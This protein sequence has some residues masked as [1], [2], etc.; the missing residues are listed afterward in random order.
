MYGFAPVKG[1]GAGVFKQSCGQLCTQNVS[2][3][4]VYQCGIE[5]AF[6]HQLLGR[7]IIIA[8]RFKVYAGLD[9][10][11]SGFAFGF[12]RV[13]EVAQHRNRTPIAVH[14]AAKTQAIAQQLAHEE[15]RGGDGL[16]VVSAVTVHHRCGKGVRND[17][18]KG[19][20]ENIEQLATA[21]FN[22]CEV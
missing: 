22:R 17:V 5:F 13:V 12:G 8:T 4:A 10:L 11:F 20:N 1:V 18:G 19:A 16:V 21:A 6:G 7:A 15:G 14:I 9:G 2:R 3:C